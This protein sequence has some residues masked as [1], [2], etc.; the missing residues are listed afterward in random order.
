MYKYEKIGDNV[1]VL[2]GDIIRVNRIQKGKSQEELSNGIC[3]TSNLSRIENNAQIPSRATY[4]KLM[5]R[6][7]LDP[8]V[9]PSFRNE[10]EVE[11]FRLKHKIIRLIF[12]GNFTEAEE[13]LNE[14]ENIPKLGREYKQYI[15]YAHVLLS[16]QKE[17]DKFEILS[18]LKNIAKMSMKDY[19]ADNIFNQIFTI[20]EIHILNSLAISC[21]ETGNTSEAI[22]LLYALKK[23]I[24]TKIVDDDSI[25]PL[26]TTILYNL[27]KYVGLN[28]RHNEVIKLCDIGIPRCIDY[29][30]YLNFAGLLFNKGFALV[31]LDKKEEAKEYLQESYYINR[32]R[33]KY[34]SC[35]IVEEF[36]KAHKIRL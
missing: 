8:N 9:Y 30:A 32:A 12:L 27:S 21:D 3:S 2:V 33:K 14:L 29:G 13:L 35:K 25:S 5:E 18:R 4:E 22:D 10:Q 15:L 17:D 1:Y 34:D 28:G 16:R 23:Y 26:Y 19:S 24:E 31:M 36:A 20:D 6:L 11:A 7:G